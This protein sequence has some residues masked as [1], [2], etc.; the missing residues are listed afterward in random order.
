MDCFPHLILNHRRK[1]E[2]ASPVEG[3]EPSRHGRSSLWRSR[4]VEE[5]SRKQWKRRNPKI[6]HSGP[7]STELAGASRMLAGHALGPTAAGSNS[8][9]SVAAR[10]REKEGCSVGAEGIPRSCSMASGLARLVRPLPEKK[11]KPAARIRKET[12]QCAH[13]GGN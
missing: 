9:W 5:E 3:R 13:I 7:P 11:K 8:C 12:M 2:L 6:M 1:R 10:S 4:E